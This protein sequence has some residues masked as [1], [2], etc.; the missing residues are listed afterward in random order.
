MF[1]HKIEWDQLDRKWMDNRIRPWV[2]KKVNAFL[3][4]DDQSLCDFICEQIGK[5]A[6]PEEILKDIA[7]VSIEVLE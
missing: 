7:M 2:A 4:E 1:V 3:G 6:T 5:Q